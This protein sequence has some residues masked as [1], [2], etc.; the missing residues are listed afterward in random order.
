M[1][2]AGNENG[3]GQGIGQRA[4]LRTGGNENGH[5]LGMRGGTGAARV[6]QMRKALSVELE[7]ALVIAGGA[8]RLAIGQLDGCQ[9]PGL[10]GVLDA[11]APR[12]AALAA[13]RHDVAADID[14][15]ILHALITQQ[16]GGA[17]EGDT[18]EVATEIERDLSVATGD[19]IAFDL[20]VG[21]R[22]RG[23][24]P[25]LKIVSGRQAGGELVRLEAPE[26][27][28]AADTGVEQVVAAGGKLLGF[29][30][31]RG[32]LVADRLRST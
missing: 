28:Q 3:F 31:E 24:A 32:K 13:Q 26:S 18:L 4:A 8:D 27:D 11:D 17:V 10:A 16:A 1:F 20:Q 14:Q 21:D 7:I 19:G 29:A 23:F 25:G 2:G 12:L 5:R 15:R 6:E 9:R 30:D 22:W